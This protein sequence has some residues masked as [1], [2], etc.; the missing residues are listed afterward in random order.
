MKNQNH[1]GVY[2]PPPLI[3]LIIFLLSVFV[4]TMIPLNAGRIDVV[5]SFSAGYLFIA[6][7]IFFDLSG[8]FQFFRTRNTI[9]TIRPANSLQ[10]DR[11][12]SVSRNPMYLG[13]LLIYC[14]FACFFGNLWT[15]LFIPV[16][17]IIIQQWVIKREEKYLHRKFGREYA[18]YKQRV[19]RWI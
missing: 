3:Y 11:I 6:A 10:T 9:V 12:Y 4:Q 19:R 18:A 17:V 7:G 1:P 13:L 5:V 14:G 16:L 15:F 8:G 2:F